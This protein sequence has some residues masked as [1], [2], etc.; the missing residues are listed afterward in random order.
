MGKQVIIFQH[1]FIKNSLMSLMINP[2]LNKSIIKIVVYSQ[3]IKRSLSLKM[4]IL[5]LFFLL[6]I[7]L[8][9]NQGFIIKSTLVKNPLKK[10]IV[11]LKNWNLIIQKKQ[12]TLKIK[13]NQIIIQDF[14]KKIIFKKKILIVIKIIQDQLFLIKIVKL[15]QQ[16]N[17]NLHYYTGT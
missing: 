9:S 3:S 16:N 10:L 11:D 4:M 6:V 1:V 5:P 2:L 7:N 17:I 14:S 12:L 8:K 13:V 15:L